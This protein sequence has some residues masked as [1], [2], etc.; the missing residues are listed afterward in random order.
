MEKNEIEKLVED[1][2]K[3]A[4]LELWQGWFKI[5]MQFGGAIIVV[6]GRRF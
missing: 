3:D 5:F 6:F 4:K 1:Q 2:I